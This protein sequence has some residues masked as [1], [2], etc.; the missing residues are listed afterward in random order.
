MCVG[1]AIDPRA[2]NVF[3]RGRIYLAATLAFARYVHSTQGAFRDYGNSTAPLVLVGP[4]DVPLP[5]PEADQAQRFAA[6][7]LLSRD[8]LEAVAWASLRPNASGIGPATCIVP[9]SAASLEAYLGHPQLGALGEAVSIH[10]ARA[11]GPRDAFLYR[12]SRS[13]RAKPPDSLEKETRRTPTGLRVRYA[14]YNAGPLR[15][16]SARRETPGGPEVDGSVGALSAFLFHTLHRN[17]VGDP[18]W[19]PLDS[20]WDRDVKHVLH[21]RAPPLNYVPTGHDDPI[22]CAVG[23]QCL[24]IHHMRLGTASDNRND[25]VADG[26]P[27]GA[28][29]NEDPSQGGGR[30]RRD[31]LVEKLGL[32]DL[33][34]IAIDAAHGRWDGGEPGP[35]WLPF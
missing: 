31:A 4:P 25:S 19:L 24:A 5:P 6:L 30:E 27:V 29:G 14:P 3:A 15:P 26:A 34:P 13:Q 32:F 33:G 16:Q 21:A 20:F 17:R 35:P 11:R 23:C 28:G 10:F 8:Q 7:S 1:W 18:G 2:A 12:G 9:P 22:Y